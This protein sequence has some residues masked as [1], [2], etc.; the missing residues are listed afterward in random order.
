M[1][2]WLFILQYIQTGSFASIGK[3]CFN[4]FISQSSIICFF[5]NFVYIHSLHLEHSK[6]RIPILLSP[7]FEEFIKVQK[8]L[9]QSDIS[10][11]KNAQNDKI[12]DNLYWE[13]WIND[14]TTANWQFTSWLNGAR[15][16]VSKVIDKIYRNTRSC[17]KWVL[18]CMVDNDSWW[19]SSEKKERNEHECT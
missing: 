6:P 11:G 9:T 10:S 14:L 7:P 1:W 18:S 3:L 5:F 16:R 15:K 17:T 13:D 2:A 4:N 19:N 8:S 12:F